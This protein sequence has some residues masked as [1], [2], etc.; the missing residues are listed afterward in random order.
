[1]MDRDLF[2]L[3]DYPETPVSEEFAR[4]VAS[5][6][7]YPFDGMTTFA[8]IAAT[9]L[10]YLDTLDLS[11]RVALERERDR[12]RAYEEWRKATPAEYERLKA[13]LNR[14]SHTRHQ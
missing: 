11:M 2:N 7:K 1:M 13:E 14:L 12:M 10:D 5:L 8:E 4:R 3:G 6:L 9:L